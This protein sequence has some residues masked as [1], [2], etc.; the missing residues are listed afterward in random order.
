MV[1][2]SLKPA[3]N[4]Y[5]DLID[6]CNSSENLSEINNNFE[7]FN[8]ALYESIVGSELVKNNLEIAFYKND[9]RGFI[10]ICKFLEINLRR[11]E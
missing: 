8:G 5:F 11:W 9:I 7:L 4:Y 3:E 1:G 10:V 2:L 6:N